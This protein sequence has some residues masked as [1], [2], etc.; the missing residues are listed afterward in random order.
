MF[1]GLFK[2][3][4]ERERLQREEEKRL[5]QQK[6]EK[7][8]RE[9]EERERKARELE[10]QRKKEEEKRR[11]QQEEEERKKRLQ[12]EELKRKKKE[13]QERQQKEEEERIKSFTV[14][15][16]PYI[17]QQLNAF[18]EKKLRK[19]LK[20][21]GYSS[22]EDK[23]RESI[24]DQ[25]REVAFWKKAKQRLESDK[26]YPFFYACLLMDEI[27][28]GYRQLRSQAKEMEGLPKSSWTYEYRFNKLSKA[29]VSFSNQLPEKLS[30]LDVAA[31][32]AIQKEFFINY[33][34]EIPKVFVK[35]ILKATSI[36]G[37]ANVCM[38]YAVLK[39]ITDN[40]F[41]KPLLRKKR[42]LVYRD[43]YGEVRRERWRQELDDFSRRRDFEAINEA[44]RTTPERF[45]IILDKLALIEEER[46]GC[47]GYE[48]GVNEDFFCWFIFRMDEEGR[49]VPVFDHVKKLSRLLEDLLEFYPD[50]EAEETEQQEE[51][52]EGPT[53]SVSPLEFEQ[54]IGRKFKILG[55]D[56][57]VTKAS[58]DQGADVVISKGDLRGV[59]Q[60]KLYS[61]PV[62][63][64][65]V[66]EVHAAKDYYEANFAVV[67]S[68]QSFT[69][70]ARMLANKLNVYLIN[71][72]EIKEFS[73]LIHTA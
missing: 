36:F 49:E 28:D 40:G 5:A 73:E 32:K 15:D 10:L 48:E 29:I 34:S 19:Q 61:Q 2:S 56:S 63:N 42:Q 6:E 22:N 24:E 50:E 26:E 46:L 58:G 17:N 33:P 38:R 57:Q 30:Q 52:V 27:V 45:K 21:I 11:L 4:E 44:C 41:L 14:Q 51:V 43:D 66:Q 35:E 37:I 70:S 18:N 25:L 3:K 20:R 64:K 53:V 72:D 67:V 71:E 9:Q 59:V 23:L 69:T 65:A 31:T 62:G 12:Q 13:Q 54:K 55:W 16:L 1:M 39:Y 68:N 47:F 8:K 7:L 60:C